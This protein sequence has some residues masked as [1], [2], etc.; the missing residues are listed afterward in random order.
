MYVAGD[1]HAGLAG[2]VPWL[3]A[4]A[5]RAAAPQDADEGNLVSLQTLMHLMVR[6]FSGSLAGYAKGALMVF[7]VEERVIAEKKVTS[8]FLVKSCEDA[9]CSG[10][11]AVGTFA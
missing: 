10:P 11:L 4:S 3:R 7:K 9:L 2:L 5:T 8:L 6:R 1:G